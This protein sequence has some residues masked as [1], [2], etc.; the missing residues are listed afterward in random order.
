MQSMTEGRK[1]VLFLARHAVFL[2][3]YLFVP[4]YPCMHRTAMKRKGTPTQ[5]TRL[6]LLASRAIQV[7]P[8]AN[9]VYR[10]D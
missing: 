9:Q 4:H 10:S 6:P 5:N 8:L 7:L 2:F 3:L 1:P